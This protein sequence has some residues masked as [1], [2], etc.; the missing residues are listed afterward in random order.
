MPS[1][2][3]SSPSFLTS[4]WITASSAVVGSSAISRAGF[5]SITDA[6]HDALA[7]A[8]GEIV[9][10]RRKRYFRIANATRCSMER[11]FSRR[12]EACPACEAPA[13]HNCR[14]MVMEGLSEVIGS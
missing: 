7:H 13:S 2:W 12:I 10:I 6:I 9:R 1:A 8:A 4:R 14:P 3:V 5:R 11:I